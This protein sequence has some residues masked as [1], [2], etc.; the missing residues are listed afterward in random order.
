MSDPH[1]SLNSWGLPGNIQQHAQTTGE[2]LIS[3][4]LPQMPCAQEHIAPGDRYYLSGPYRGEP[5]EIPACICQYPQELNPGCAVRTALALAP[6]LT[7]SF[8]CFPGLNFTTLVA[9][10]LMGLPV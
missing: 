3:P 2:A 7:E 10:I 9:G 1:P 5:A 4:K 6:Y 8:S